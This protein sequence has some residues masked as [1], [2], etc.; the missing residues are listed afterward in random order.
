MPLKTTS[1]SLSLTS[2]MRGISSPEGRSFPLWAWPQ[3]A[4]QVRSFVGASPYHHLWHM[5]ASKSDGSTT[6][7]SSCICR[8][9]HQPKSN[10]EVSRRN[11]RFLSK[12]RFISWKAFHWQA[13]W[14]LKDSQDS[15]Q[16]LLKGTLRG[17]SKSVMN[18]HLRP[19]CRNSAVSTLPQMLC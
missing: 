18:H 14:N 15:A 12:R 3:A 19:T 16:K 13:L 2:E 4:A 7:I 11:G 9:Y 6:L 1:G 10:F 5:G 17:D 8:T